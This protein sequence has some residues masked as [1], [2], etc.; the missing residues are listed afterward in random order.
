MNQDFLNIEMVDGHP[1]YSTPFQFVKKKKLF[2]QDIQSAQRPTRSHKGR[3]GLDIP[4][5]IETQF[6]S[7]TRTRINTALYYYTEL[8]FFSTSKLTTDALASLLAL[9]VQHRFIM[10]FNLLSM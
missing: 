8:Y 5:K 2:D 4:F 6:L 7:I 9:S 3:P 1:N 10:S